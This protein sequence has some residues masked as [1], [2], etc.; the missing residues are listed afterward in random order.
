MV[1]DLGDSVTHIVPVYDGHAMPHLTRR[2]DMAGRDVTRYLIKLLLM[3]GYAF[4]HTADG[5]R[6]QGEVVLSFLFFLRR[7]DV[8]SLI[9]SLDA[10]NAYI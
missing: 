1:V 2:L 8:L 6:D 7:V 9:H 10:Y 5:Q 3:H 4:N